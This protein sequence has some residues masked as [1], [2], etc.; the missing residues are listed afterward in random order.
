MVV[1]SLDAKQGSK[2]REVVAMS[3]EEGISSTAQAHPVASA[4]TESRYSVA[5]S[6][7]VGLRRTPSARLVPVFRCSVGHYHAAMRGSES[8]W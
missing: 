5:E 8:S 7:I 1:G 4:V 3:D 6:G 2:T